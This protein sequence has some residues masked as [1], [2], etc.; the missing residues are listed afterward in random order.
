MEV[1]ALSECGF[2]TPPRNRV[3]VTFS[4]QFISVS[5]CLRVCLCVWMLVNTFKPNGCTGHNQ[6]SQSWR[7]LRSLKASWFFFNLHVH[8]YLQDICLLISKVNRYNF[9]KNACIISF[10]WKPYL[11]DKLKSCY[12]VPKF[13]SSFI[14]T[15][16]FS[17]LLSSESICCFWCLL[18]F[19]LC[20]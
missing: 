12:H 5:V 19:P 14:A 10:A 3:G 4:L 1:S 17:S 9:F 6:R 11:A 8:L 18:W 13:D 15:P 2:F 20:L 16:F 7:C